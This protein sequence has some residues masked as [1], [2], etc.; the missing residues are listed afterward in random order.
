M[1]ESKKRVLTMLR[2]RQ[3]SVFAIGLGLAASVQAESLSAGDCAEGG[4]FI[5]NAA[6]SR[7][8]GIAAERFIATLEDDLSR[9]RDMPAA[10]RWFAYSDIEEQLLRKATLGVFMRPKN[11]DIHRAEFVRLCDTVRNSVAYQD[12]KRPAAAN[13]GL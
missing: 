2:K 13:A 8:N 11:A 6:L 1:L 10:A 4:D 5:K 9:V 7:D 12:T 3:L